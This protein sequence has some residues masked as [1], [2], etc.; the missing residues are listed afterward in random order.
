[1]QLNSNDNAPNRRFH[2][3]RSRLWFSQ[4]EKYKCPLLYRQMV[5]L[6]T[7]ELLLGHSKLGEK[8]IQFGAMVNS[9]LA[10]HWSTLAG[11]PPHRQCRGC[12]R[13]SPTG[14]RSRQRDGHVASP[15]P[16]NR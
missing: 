7:C 9:K 6:R 10:S 16:G 11:A 3:Y 4:L 14:K 1:M 15:E 5:N 13:F 8:F 12:E 2:V